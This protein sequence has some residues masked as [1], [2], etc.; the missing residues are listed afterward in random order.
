MDCDTGAKLPGW[1]RRLDIDK[2][3]QP[4]SGLQRPDERGAGGRDGK[5]AA[6]TPEAKC[7]G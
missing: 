4:E 3:V 2:V 5:A 1:W 7:L 6:G